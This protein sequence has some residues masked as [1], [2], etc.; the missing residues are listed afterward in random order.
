MPKLT[1]LTGRTVGVWLVERL[2]PGRSRRGDR[3][4]LCRC[5]ECGHVA[6]LTTDQLS[7]E[8]PLSLVGR[9]D[10]EHRMERPGSPAWRRRRALEMREAGATLAE[11]ADAIGVSRQRAYQIVGPRPP[12]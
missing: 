8:P 1:D 9:C 10:R 11:I 3:V 5:A 7:R 2:A 6:G 12:S 4:W